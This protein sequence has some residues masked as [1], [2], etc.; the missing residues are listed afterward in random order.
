MACNSC[1]KSKKL[2]GCYPKKCEPVQCGCPV[3]VTS[4]CVTV[5][6]DLECAGILGGQTLTEVMVQWDAFICEKFDFLAA[7]FQIVNIGTGAEIFAGTSPTGQKQL[8]TLSST[9]SITVTENTNDITFAVDPE[10]LEDQISESTISCIVS[11]TLTITEEEGCIRIEQPQTADIPALY[12]NS[13][14]MGIDEEGSLSKPFKTIQAAL[15]TFFGSGSAENP[16]L[17]GSEIIVQKG[18]GTY[19]FTGNLNTT[20]L[21]FT[22]EEGTAIL[23]NPSSGDWFCD[24]DAMSD[25]AFTLNIV[26]KENSILTFQKSGFRN[27]GTTTA[28]NNFLNSKIVFVTLTPSSRL[29]QNSNNISANQFCILESN[30]S[31]SNTFNNDGNRTFSVI[32]GNIRSNTQSIYKVGGNSRIL[33]DDSMFVIQGYA[34]LPTSIKFMDQIGGLIEMTGCS[35]NVIPVEA[36]VL[37]SFI[38]LS[39]SATIPC[40]LI[41]SNMLLKGKMAT[42]FTNTSGLQPV[43]QVA[44]S[45]TSQ[46]TCTDISKSPSVLWTNCELYGNTFTDGILDSTEVDITGNNT[47]STYNIFGKNFHEA[48]RI[49]P[50]KADAILAGLSKGDAFINRRTVNALNLIPGEEYQV[51]TSGTGPSLG[52]VGTYFIATSGMLTST[53]TAYFIKRDVV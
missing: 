6:P 14:Y 21:T 35:A 31:T 40:N 41:I 20:D 29:I 44:S 37:D 30:Y 23:S 16:E 25:N 26:L 13:A 36:I 28:T 46:F 11:D 15:A 3:L 5:L 1:N 43:L 22:L 42:V 38:T 19:T 8:R 32:S 39:K 18:A 24:Y 10:W 51:L 53:G 33:F 17:A 50:S 49:Y 45:Q 12:V 4:D 7:F 47:R 52:T 34:G 2:C 48:L 9:E 27:S